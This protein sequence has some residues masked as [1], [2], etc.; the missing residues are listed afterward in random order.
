MNTVEITRL[1]ALAR[2][3]DLSRAAFIRRAVLVAEHRLEDV[4]RI[5]KESGVEGWGVGRPPGKGRR[6]E[7]GTG[8]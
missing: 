6:G 7:A 3:T 4:R 2:A 8:Q 1:E 5:P